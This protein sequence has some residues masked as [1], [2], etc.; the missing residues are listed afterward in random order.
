MTCSHPTDEYYVPESKPQTDKQDN[1]ILP[2]KPSPDASNCG[3]VNPNNDD[4]KEAREPQPSRSPSTSAPSSLTAV[5]SNPPKPCLLTLPLE[6]RLEILSYL[7]V[8][9]TS[10]PPPSQSFSKHSPPPPPRSLHPAVLRCSKQLHLEAL[11]LLYRHNT[12]QAH[13]T[14]LTALPRLRRAYDPVLS[15][16]LAALIARVH[17]CVR[18]D[19]EPRYGRA[20]ATAQLTGREEVV[21]EA[22]QAMWRGSGPDVLRLF[23]GV[24]GVRRA[25]VVGSVGGFEEYARWL[26]R[27]MMREVGA[28]VEPFFWNAGREYEPSW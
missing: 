24:R 5:P 21:L 1:I 20:E 10:T 14:L 7:L 28:T 17:V 15:D 26:E 22:W 4:G 6:L 27:A 13:S 25:K 3:T 16:R 8:L 9:P 12:F 18:L 19:A 11:P 2:I 23:E